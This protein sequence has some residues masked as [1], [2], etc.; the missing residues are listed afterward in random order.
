MLT[1]LHESHMQIYYSRQQC[2]T[3]GHLCK[4]SCTTEKRHFYVR[5]LFMQIMRVKH[6][7]HK[8]VS[9]NFFIAPNIVMHETLKYINKK[10]KFFE[11]YVLT[12]LHKLFTHIKMSLYGII[13]YQISFSYHL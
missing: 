1:Q 5:V 13:Y 4:L 7:L 6:L 10:H 9:H 3:S 11:R 2:M 12:D 8:F